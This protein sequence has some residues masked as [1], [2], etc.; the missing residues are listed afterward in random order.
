M[1]GVI[2]ISGERSNIGVIKYCNTKITELIKYSP[3]E[4]LGQNVNI[5]M[6][7]FIGSMHD[8]I[9]MSYL[10]LTKSKYDNVERLAPMID[11][12]N[13]LVFARILTKP[14][15]SLFNGL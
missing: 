3:H 14:L 12:D 8:D 4:L 15:P 11:K 6:P 7:K 13:Y 9:L 5:L 10:E 2:I 1:T